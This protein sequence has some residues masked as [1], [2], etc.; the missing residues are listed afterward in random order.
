MTVDQ[1]HKLP[2]SSAL[3]SISDGWQK[4]PKDSRFT[5]KPLKH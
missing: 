2:Y 5:F 3:E 4:F 1:H